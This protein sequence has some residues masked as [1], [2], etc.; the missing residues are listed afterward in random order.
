MPVLTIGGI[1]VS[2]PFT[3]YK[4]QEDYMAQVIDCL[5]L[6]KNGILESPTGTGKTLCL[7]CATLA[8]REHQ[9]G[10]HV[11]Q[12]EQQNSWGDDGREAEAAVTY[13]GGVG[14]IPKIIY[15]SRTHSQLSQ[16][17]NELKNA[18]YK[19]R[20]CVLG[21]R[22]QLCI[23]P[24]VV[25]QE[26]NHAKVH[27]CRA[28]TTSRSCFYYN[29][30][31]EKKTDFIAGIM[32]VEE[33]VKKGKKH[34]VCP[35]FM[36]QELKHDADIIFMPYNYLL[37]TKSRRAHSIDLSGKIVIF[38]EA[39]NVERLCENAASFDLTPF[40][41][42]S[43]IDAVSHFL[44]MKVKEEELLGSTDKF[45]GDGSSTDVSIEDVANI[46]QLLLNLEREIDLVE[47][48]RGG[49]ITK[50]GSF[51][52]ELFERAGIGSQIMKTLMD[53]LESI[54]GAITIK[55]GIFN[56]TTGIQNLL[57]AFQIAFSHENRQR[58]N[59]ETYYKVHIRM[60]DSNWKKKQQQKADPWAVASSAKKQGKVV[61]YW[62]FSPGH[63]M[64]ELLQQNVRCLILT[65]GT[66]SPMASFTAEL[67]IDFPIKLEN[68][69]V[70]DKHQVW[71]G[72]V[73]KGPDSVQLNSAYRNRSCPAYMSSLGK[74]I[75]NLA[76]IIPNG[77]LVFF[78]S[79]TVM[80]MC[81]QHWK[82]EGLSSKIEEI[83][84]MFVEPKQK[85]LFTEAIN[86]F[87]DKI[88]DPRCSAAAFF[89]VCRGKVSEGLD[90]ADANGRA[91]II[92]G[93]PFPPQMDPWIK[94]KMQFLD[95]MKAKRSTEMQFVGLSGQEWYTQQASRA[96][97]Q[98]IGRVIRHRHDYGAIIL[99]DH[100]FSSAS[101]V[102]QLPSWMRPSVKAYP[103]FGAV[104][105]E[106]SQFFRTATKMLPAPQRKVSCRGQV[107]CGEADGAGC[108]SSSLQANACGDLRK[109]RAVD[110]H[111]PS[112]RRLAADPG[113]YHAGVSGLARLCVE[114]EPEDGRPACRPAG[115]LD[116]LEFSE[117]RERNGVSHLPGEEQ[118]YWL[119]T[120]TLR[121]DKILDD[122]QRGS[123]KKMVVVSNHQ[124]RAHA[125]GVA[126]GSSKRSN[127]TPASHVERS[128]AYIQDVRRTL[129]QENH[130]NFCSAMHEYK[131][132][133]DL[134][135]LFQKL[136]PIFTEDP[137]KY[138][139]L[140]QFY[141][142]VRPH[143]KKAFDETCRD[144]TGEGCGY[145]A[146]HSLTREQRT[147]LLQQNAAQSGVQTKRKLSSEDG[148]VHG[149]PKSK[150]G[151]S[152]AISAESSAQE[153]DSSTHLN[154][155]AGHLRPLEQ[156]STSC[157]VVAVPEKPTA[158]TAKQRDVEQE[159]CRKACARYVDEVRILLGAG[160][161]DR[162]FGALKDYR[163]SGDFQAMVAALAALFLED[164]THA[165]L[166]RKFSVFILQQH[167]EKFE[168]VCRDLTGEGC[169]W[170][171]RQAQKARSDGVGAPA[172]T[173]SQNAGKRDTISGQSKI[174]SFFGGT[175]RKA[176]ALGSNRGAAQMQSGGSEQPGSS[177]Q[178]GLTVQQSSSAARPANVKSGAEQTGHP[179]P[180]GLDSQINFLLKYEDHYYERTKCGMCKLKAS[181]YLACP[182]CSVVGCARCWRLW[183][184]LTQT[185]P[186]C[187]EA[188][189]WR[190]LLPFFH[191]FE[192]EC[193][194]L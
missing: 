191:M 21:S 127:P 85:G 115:L 84:P 122:E 22:E 80:D 103:E 50:Q 159:R 31:E 170:G 46:K 77:L 143:H 25:K 145:V 160:E 175:D 58:A 174:S 161:F 12:R 49:S 104:V 24:D 177:A 149:N 28:K 164:P 69:H 106:L 132:M 117:R 44:Q 150:L 141:I 82:N 23:H 33:L 79:Y 176:E 68:P 163:S 16:A 144:L 137:M 152:A 158:Q 155:G 14:N 167:R 183:C 140:R 162:F 125:G 9:V 64:K 57:E 8:W 6:G 121:H 26:S 48:P 135:L 119:S 124:E 15:S 52:F 184:K 178:S 189:R 1:P 40:E 73:E 156:A 97:N 92:T 110:A 130:A 93:L 148:S 62:C 138:R 2:F 139:L 131:R 47:L 90:F 112:L 173:A 76:R 187:S 66:L 120:Q 32:D 107:A 116:A 89:A 136:G 13:P 70:I 59:M 188:I 193:E 19:P 5:N 126:E 65:S 87:Y 142:F 129:S 10:Q 171:H 133:D 38:D 54:V 114:F 186:D 20:V 56:N 185:C 118:A 147:E 179:V 43:S 105:R 91:V 53:G 192:E 134:Q 74:T 123:K 109:A 99:C 96:V 18:S 154:K 128:R 98:A 182:S 30:V 51:L 83:K 94:L 60:D 41:L 75:V 17:M 153:L 100:R 81:L 194:D 3:P 111:V 7:L 78:P 39:H 95:E 166:L 180:K 169:D 113:D 11:R 181:A 168:G 190:N 146:E 71:V 36:T 34:Q 108:S 27:L 29:N 151:C 72:I 61:S 63:T 88:N 172:S 102:A 157:A 165:M 45:N 4:C 55:T 101:A 67:Q 42:A 37:D 86:G 35:Y